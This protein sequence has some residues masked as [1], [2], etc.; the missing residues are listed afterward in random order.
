MLAAT[1]LA[2]VSAIAVAGPAQ[3]EDGPAGTA[4]GARAKLGNLL[5]QESGTVKIGEKSISAGLFSLSVEGGGELKTYCVDI[6]HQTRNGSVY[7]E[8]DWA[9]STLHSNEDAGKIVW[10]LENSYPKVNDLAKLGEAA[11]LGAKDL[12]A[13]EAATGT[14]AAIWWFS[15]KVNAVPKEADAKKLTDYLKDKAQQLQEPAPSITLDPA[16]VS[17]KAGEK[18]G[19][20]KVNT[21][22]QA[23]VSLDAAAQSADVKVVNKDG[24][25]V[26]TV[27][28]GDELY[29]DVPAGAEPG[30]ASLTVKAQTVVPVGRVFV[31]EGSQ[32]QILAGSS[33][34][35]V[36]ATATA[37][38]AAP[39]SKGPIPAITTAN[40][41]AEGGVDITVSN[42]GDEE[43]VFELEGKEYTIGAG[44]TETV[45]FPVKEDEAYKVS[46]AMPDGTEKVFEGVLNCKT[47]STNGGSAGGSATGGGNEPTPASAG[48][49]SEGSS[50]TD[51]GSTTG[52]DLAETGS[53]SSTPLIAGLAV[54]LLAVGGGTV[55]F[56]RKRK[57]GTPAA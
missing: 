13:A 31:S 37:T 51:G 16:A 46:I 28:G 56:L 29:F 4:A 34:A 35:T 21:T 50:S 39:D 55:F 11:G 23:E 6:F 41:C 42:E 40:N 2:A 15:D 25:A 57:A 12:D 22:A 27:A 47:D 17:G 53:S 38:W 36:Q 49:S 24:Q 8:T 18:L 20:V 44:K 5:E 52:G 26:T 48:G 10:I 14:Q 7:Q 3:A 9:K 1:S 32:T 19:P 30:V 54:V 43:F 33:Q 45:L